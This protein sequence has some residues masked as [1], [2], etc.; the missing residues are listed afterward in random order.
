MASGTDLATLK[1]DSLHLARFLRSTFEELRAS[2]RAGGSYA[3][4]VTQNT[5]AADTP[6]A[7]KNGK[8]DA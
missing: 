6:T 1:Q 3:P 5:P 8:H 2:K 4:N 7:D